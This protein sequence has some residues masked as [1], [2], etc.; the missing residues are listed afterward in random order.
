[1]DP[2]FPFF[3]APR[4]V[5][6]CYCRAAAVYRVQGGGRRGV[7]GV[8]RGDHQPGYPDPAPLPLP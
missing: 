3:R 5:L 8:R 1:M 2:Y 7:P 6:P 4:P